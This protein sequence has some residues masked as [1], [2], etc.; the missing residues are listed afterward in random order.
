MFYSPMIRELL[1]L[2]CDLHEGFPA[3]HLPA[4]GIAWPEGAGVGAGEVNWFPL[5]VLSLSTECSGA[6]KI[7]FPPA[8]SVGE[9]SLILM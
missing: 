3:P 6:F 8:G 4:G 2:D 7:L 1:P 9:F 5:R